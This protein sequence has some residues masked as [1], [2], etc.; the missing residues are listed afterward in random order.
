MDSTDA[1]REKIS[2]AVV[3]G[4]LLPASGENLAVLIQGSKSP[5]YVAALNELVDKRAWQELNDRF[6]CTLAFGTGGLRGRTIGRLTAEAEQGNASRESC[7]E[8]P[9]VG[10]NAMNFFNVSRATQGLAA[11]LK[12]QVPLTTENQKHKVCVCHDTRYFSRA[13]AE[14][15]AKVLSDLGCDVFLFEAARS[16]PE[17]SF[18]IRMTQSAAGINLTASHNPPPYN[19]YKVYFSDGG[20]IVEPHASGIIAEVDRISSEDYTPLGEADRGRI[21]PLGTEID[22]AYIERLQTLLLEPEK[23]RKS[24]SLRVVYSPL[25]GTGA[26]IIQPL[27]ERI[28]VSC[29]LVKEQATQDG[30]FPTVT[31]PNPEDPQAFEMALKQADKEEAD[32]VLATDPDGDRMG[33]A[34]RD[35][36]GTLRLLSGNQIGSILAWHRL[37]RFFAT[38]ILNSENR[39]R[40]TII[41]TFVTTDLQKVIARSFGVQCVET[42][43]GFK[44]IGAKL[45]KYEQAI[46]AE[47]R[48]DYISLTEEKTRQLRL[49][50]STFFVFGGEES[51]GYSGSDFVRDKDAAASVTMICD[52]A[53]WAGEQGWTLIDL[54]DQI[55][56]KHGYF[57]ERGESL[58]MEGAEGAG[59][60]KR[61][62]SSYQNMPPGQMGSFAV[63]ETKDFSKPGLLDSEGDPLP[64]ENMLIFELEDGFRVAVRPS[65]TEPKIKFY[66]FGAEL[67]ADSSGLD[68]HGLKTAK[69]RVTRALEDLW[70][71]VQSDISNRTQAKGD[72]TPT[73]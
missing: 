50:H 72:S 2:A 5:V 32:L 48:K 43:T 54:L 18:A 63:V 64:C 62:I 19:G 16:T 59:K 42:L 71:W 23:I 58:K 61:L 22:E 73:T 12:N 13:F 46:P 70:H 29:S 52:A 44:Y 1:L 26:A 30:G 27:L 4:D 15:T 56:R 66:L 8:H 24:G 11:Y 28:G 3:S 45:L 14:F 34:A 51:F 57:L 39:S 65:G 55:Y 31:S 6:Y 35:S 21:L 69:A 38:G 33:A 53:F 37:G 17:L 40:A 67:P 7:P 9:C 41:K 10:T 49:D 60:I 25:H 68:A 36:S 20:Q 47:L